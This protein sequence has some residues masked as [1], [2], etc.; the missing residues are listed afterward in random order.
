MKITE[1]IIESGKIDREYNILMLSDLHNKP[2]GKILEQVREEN[3]DLLLIA[4]DLVDRHRKT[5]RRVIP[6]LR[7]C[8]ETAP[9]YMSM[10]NHEIK[11]PVIRPSEIRETGVILLD[12]DYVP[13]GDLLI[14]GHS[15]GTG[16]EWLD[17]FESE[18]KFKILLNHH[19]EDWKKHLKD[20]SIDLILSGHAHGGQIRLFGTPLFAPGQGIFPRYTKGF[21]G[22][23]IVGTGV[24]NTA[25]L[26]PRYGNPR[27]IVKIKLIPEKQG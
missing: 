3:P 1:Y 13:F 19:P 22:N 27:E 20:R 11:F 4:G 2:Y 9:T 23:M 18:D 6:F 7:E 24:S 26:I 14:G 5:Y 16:R 21:Y 25:P 17:R 15:P 12:N 10:G 8:A